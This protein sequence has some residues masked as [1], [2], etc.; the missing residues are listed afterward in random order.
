M[1]AEAMAGTGIVISGT[2]I[3]ISSAGLDA[4]NLLRQIQSHVGGKGG[5]SPKSANGTLGRTV[6]E[7]ELMD[8]LL[9][10]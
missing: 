4:R 3:A 8:I 7:N 1:I 6:T 9:Q 5:G 10:E 2:Q